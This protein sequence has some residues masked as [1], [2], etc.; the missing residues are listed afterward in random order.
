[1]KD[2]MIFKGVLE[3]IRFTKRTLSMIAEKIRSEQ[4]EKKR[5]ELKIDELKEKLVEAKHLRYQEFSEDIESMRQRLTIQINEFDNKEN[6]WQ[7]ER[8]AYENKIHDLN[9]KL[10]ALGSEKD[11][12]FVKT[13]MR[14]RMETDAKSISQLFEQLDEARTNLAKHEMFS[15][16]YS[17]GME[18]MYKEYATLQEENSDIKNK[19]EELRK[20]MEN[21]NRYR[22]MAMMGLEEVD[23][24]KQRFHKKLKDLQL[25]YE[26][27]QRLT[28][29]LK[30]LSMQDDRPSIAREDNGEEILS[31][32]SRYFSR[33]DRLFYRTVL[34]T[35][36]YA[37]L[38]P[39]YLEKK[40][41][42]KSGNIF[43][44]TDR[45]KS[46]I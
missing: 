46:K 3:I 45:V 41:V 7:A 37:G 13:Q 12:E 8:S 43:F 26:R 29:K 24:L 2:E 33:C 6:K 36:N 1:L 44:I 21:T 15:K 22:E 9:A 18:N 17:K 20:D 39:N 14:K 42:D 34:Y 38:L 16:F 19:I 32:V 4:D 28:E 40:S 10:E 27:H 5:K 11:A 25:F 23:G 35:E 30:K 31:A